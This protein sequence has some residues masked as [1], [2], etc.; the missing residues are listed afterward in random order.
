M[1]SRIL[2]ITL[3]LRG[4]ISPGE[5]ICRMNLGYL[6]HEPIDHREVAFYVLEADNHKVE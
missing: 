4:E 1:S 6:D 3:H 2:E 5:H